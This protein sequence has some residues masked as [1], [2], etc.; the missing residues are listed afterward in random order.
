MAFIREYQEGDFDDIVEICK[1]TAHPSTHSSADILPYI[2]AIPYIRLEPIHA[3][4]LDAGSSDSSSGR[5]VVG[6]IIGTPDTNTF[7]ERY[8]EAYLPTL[9]PAIA[10]TTTADT[11]ATAQADDG[12]GDELRRMFGRILLNPEDMLHPATPDFIPCYPAHLHINI[13]PGF[14]SKGFGGKLM[15]RFLRGLR[16][17]ETGVCG[18]HLGM[19]RDNVAAGRF[20]ER[21]GFR[22]H[23]ELSDEHTALMVKGLEEVGGE[24]AKNQW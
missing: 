20:Y 7:A 4:V 11:P 12:D 24:G 2:Y 1:L 10:N 15:E 13:L 3:F 21:C 14:Q 5:R 22:L 9:P 18:L 8:K 23:E 16:A 17:R 19:R 6:Y